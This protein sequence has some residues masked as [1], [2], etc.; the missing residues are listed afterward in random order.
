MRSRS[1]TTT[2]STRTMGRSWF[3]TAAAPRRPAICTRCR[4]CATGSGTSACVRSHY[5]H[6]HAIQVIYALLPEIAGNIIDRC[7]GA[8]I[9]VWGGKGGAG[10]DWGGDGGR[11]DYPAAV[12]CSDPSQQGDEFPAEHE[13]LGRDRVLAARPRLYL[14]QHLGQPG[15]IPALERR[16]G[17]QD[18]RRTRSRYGQVRLC[19]LPGRRLQILRVQQRRLGQEQRP[20]ESS[21]RDRRVPRGGRVHERDLQQHRIPVRRSLPAPGVV[22]RPQRLPGQPRDGFERSCVPPRRHHR[23]GGHQPPAHG[24]EALSRS[25]PWLTPTTFS[26]AGH[27][28]SAISI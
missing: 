12:A 1:P 27:A 14:R 9:Y 18:G 15:R 4:S 21:V 8:G 17:R 16:G 13:R 24:R 6:G 26:W 3:R 28:S 25:R 20:D 2:S 7:W 19:V 22:R 23:S 10:Q 11:S 5:D